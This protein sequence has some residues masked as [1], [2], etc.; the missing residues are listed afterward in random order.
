M[1]KIEDI[2]YVQFCGGPRPDWEALGLNPS[3]NTA[4]RIT[5]NVGFGSVPQSSRN[6]A[7][8]ADDHD[9]IIL[10]R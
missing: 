2:D 3:S 1:G 7:R 9:H 5:A 6:G 8:K 4:S 10:G